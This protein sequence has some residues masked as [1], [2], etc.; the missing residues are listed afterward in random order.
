MGV[1]DWSKGLGNRASGVS[2]DIRLRGMYAGDK[3]KSGWQKVPGN[4][5]I[6]AGVGLM[7]GLAVGGAKKGLG[8]ARW[9]QNKTF[10]AMQKTYGGWIIIFPILIAIL[11]YATGKNGIPLDFLFNNSNLFVDIATRIIADSPYW[12]FLAIFLVLRKPFGRPDAKNEIMFLAVYMFITFFTMVVGGAN[13]WIFYHLG[14]ALLTFAF[15]LKGF[16]SNE[17]IGQRHWIFLIILAVDIF[18]L[19]TFKKMYDSGFFAFTLPGLFLN[20]ILFPWWFF[21]YLALI[22]DSSFKTGATIF[23]ILFYGGLAG[24]EYVGEQTIDLQP[25]TTEQGQ[26]ARGIAQSI[27]N[28]RDYATKWFTG[29][30]E[31][32]ITGKVEENQ[33]EPLGVY[34]ENVKPADERYYLDEPIIVWGSVKA[35]TLDDPINIKVGCF[36]EKDKAKLYA[37]PPYGQTDPNKTFSVFTLEEQDFA[38]TFNACEKGKT[39]NRKDGSK[40]IKAYA[41]FNFETLAYLKVYLINTE[42]LRAMSREGLDPFNELG[43]T[44]RNPVAVYTNGPAKIEMGTND[45]LIGVSEDYVVEPSIGVKISNKEGWEGKIK[46]L[47]ELLL[48]LPD[49]SKLNRGSC[50]EVFTDYTVSECKDVSCQKYVK[51]ECMDVCNGSQADSPK[52]NSCTAACNKEFDECKDSCDSFFQ[53]GGQSYKGYS[54]VQKAEDKNKEI[55]KEFSVRCRFRPD[56]AKILSNAPVTTK[57][58]RV[59]ARYDYSVEKSTSVN[60]INPEEKG[61]E[62]F[63]GAPGNLAIKNEDNAPVSEGPITLGPGITIVWGKSINDGGGSNDVIKYRIYR[64]DGDSAEWKNIGEINVE[65]S[66]NKKASYEYADTTVGITNDFKYSYYADALNDE[67]SFEKSDKI[68]IV[69]KAGDKPAEVVSNDN[70]KLTV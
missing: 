29:R 27:A 45:Q 44:D 10:G 25:L 58:F 20:R 2:D 50:N 47:K 34:L 62:G 26:A 53:E 40:T 42:R 52:Y 5:K 69:S 48:F 7:A 3:V 67:N 59:K 46:R 17:P 23:V 65:D 18:G 13:F 35:R 4:A 68:L 8:A 37:Q 60:I 41:D 6:G 54:L 16:D 43:I 66:A 38:C 1:G 70:E 56:P 64:R 19:A 55:D 12:V 22:R 33:Y 28:W 51:D 39:C 24:F 49:G 61:G 21:Y 15:L 63:V 30:I 31:Y 14:F 36:M 9:A 57:S 32:A 11:D